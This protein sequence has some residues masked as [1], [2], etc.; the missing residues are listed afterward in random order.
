[1]QWLLLIPIM[2]FV[3]FILC[4][5]FTF[6]QYIV[7]DTTFTENLL[8]FKSLFLYPYYTLIDVCSF[9]IGKYRS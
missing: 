3:Y 4:L 2:I 6:I 5:F 9:L 8:Y 1:M 7:S